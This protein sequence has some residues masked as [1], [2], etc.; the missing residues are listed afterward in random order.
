MKLRINANHDKLL[1]IVLDT[2]TQMTRFQK[3]VSP[4]ES[5]LSNWVA[6]YYSPEHNWAVCYDQRKDDN[7][8]EVEARLNRI[9]QRLLSMPGDPQTILEVDTPHGRVRRAKRQI[10][11]DMK[12]EWTRII[13]AVN[14]INTAVTQ[15]KGAHQ[16]AFNVGVQHRNAQYPFWVS[17]GLACV[18]ETPPQNKRSRRLGAARTN[19]LRLGEYRTRRRGGKSLG[20]SGLIT[21]KRND[22]TQSV[23]AIYAESWAVFAFLF[24]RY[25]TQLSAYLA[26]LAER[27][28]ATGDKPINELAEFQRFFETPIPRLQAKFDDY[29]ERL[30]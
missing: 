26:G 8:A 22:L 6:G 28:P 12:N 2:R 17:E 4:D 14:E 16:L 30:K 13:S 9:A 18:F 27:Q 15:H 24:D 7:L 25:P 21:L 5:R 3:E 10:G 19:G 1:V 29:I 20:L 11:Q 23:N